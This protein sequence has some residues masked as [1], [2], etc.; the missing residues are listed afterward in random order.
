MLASFQVL[1]T[2]YAAG[3]VAS[4]ITLLT[5]GDTV[6]VID[7]GMVADRQLILGPLAEVGIEPR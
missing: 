1:P 2:G 6:G 5:E 7:P 3:R 4:A